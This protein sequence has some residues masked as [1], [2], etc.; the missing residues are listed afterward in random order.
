MTEVEL[1]AGNLS[2]AIRQLRNS[3][4]A[5]SAAS[6]GKELTHQQ[7]VVAHRELEDALGPMQ[8]VRALLETVSESPTT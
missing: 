7:M 4:N 1:A 8:Q 5:I 3:Y 6:L 2:S